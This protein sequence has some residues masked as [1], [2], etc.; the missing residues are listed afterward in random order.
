M[1]C[2]LS[3]W[4]MFTPDDAPCQEEL[5]LLS[6]IVF[7]HITLALPASVFLGTEVDL[8]LGTEVD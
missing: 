4:K 7:L 8:F 2:Y 1:L 5:S 6:T 3:K